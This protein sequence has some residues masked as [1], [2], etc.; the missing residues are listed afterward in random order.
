MLDKNVDD[1]YAQ[2]AIRE[3]FFATMS[4]KKA[5]VVKKVIKS[6]ETAF[7]IVEDKNGQ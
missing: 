6:L 4:K 3:I 2:E 1:W 7:L 5:K